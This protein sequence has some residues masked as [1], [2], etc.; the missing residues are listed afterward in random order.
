MNG[1]IAYPVIQIIIAVFKKVQAV[2]PGMF[3]YKNFSKQQFSNAD[4]K[5]ISSNL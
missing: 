2:N 4:D 1:P 3:D 5:H